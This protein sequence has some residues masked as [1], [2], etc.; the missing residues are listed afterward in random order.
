MDKVKLSRLAIVTMHLVDKNCDEFDWCYVE[1]HENNKHM[2]ALYGPKGGNP[3]IEI[4]SDSK[5]EAWER[6]AE[7]IVGIE[8]RRSEDGNLKNHKSED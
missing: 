4:L 7:A 3:E 5:C 8:L 6:M 2:I 1:Q